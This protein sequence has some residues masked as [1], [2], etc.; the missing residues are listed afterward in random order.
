M[1][2]GG[3][4]SGYSA[5]TSLNV[6]CHRSPAKVSTLVLCTSVRCLRVAAAGQLE[7]VADAALDAH[8]GVDRALGGDLVRRALAQERRPRRRRCPRCSRGSPPSRCPSA[9]QERAL[10]DVEVEVEAHLQQQAPLDHARAARRA[11]RRR[12]AAGRRGRATRRAPRRAGRCRRAGSGRRR[13]RSRRCRGRRRRRATTF[14]ASAMTSG[15]MPSPPMTPT[16]CPTPAPVALIV[17]V[18]SRRN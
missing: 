13:G 3:A 4:T 6:R 9:A 18:M 1:V 2:V 17:A 11:C 16:L 8:A 14:R 7:G 15:P 12:R 5:A 10:V